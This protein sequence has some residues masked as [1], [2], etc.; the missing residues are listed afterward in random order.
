[1]DTMIGSMTLARTKNGLCWLSFNQGD[2]AL[3]A[4]EMWS[5]RHF[6]TDQMKKDDLALEEIRIQLEEYFSQ[7]RKVFDMELDMIGTPFQKM[8]WNALLHIPY[9]EIRSYK[10]IAQ[11]IGAPK[12]IRAIGG[13]NN[14]NHI[15]II[16]PCHRVIG[17]NGALVGYSCGVHIKQQL[18]ELEGYQVKGIDRKTSN[19]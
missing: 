2:S 4:L 14:K 10:E 1:M 3:R 11:I 8:V 5:R 7:K 13:A 16:V 9:G 18:L 17:S 6:L 12:A 19:L 15:P